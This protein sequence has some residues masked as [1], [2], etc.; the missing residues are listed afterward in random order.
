MVLTSP[1]RFTIVYYPIGKLVR[2]SLKELKPPFP[3]NKTKP[4]EEK[5]AISLSDSFLQ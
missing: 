5:S 2:L 3:S 4:W 1:P